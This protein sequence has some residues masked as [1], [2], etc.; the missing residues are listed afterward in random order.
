MRSDP[1]NKINLK[2]RKSHESLSHAGQHKY[3]KKIKIGFDNDSNKYL[4]KFFHWGLK[5]PA[6]FENFSK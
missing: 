1:L 4:N 6:T 3:Q 2:I 5:E